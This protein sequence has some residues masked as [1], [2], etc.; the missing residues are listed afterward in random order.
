MCRGLTNERQN[1]PPAFDRPKVRSVVSW[2]W[3]YMQACLRKEEAPVKI[4]VSITIELSTTTV[5]S[6]LLIL[7]KAIFSALK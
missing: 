5:F 6:K 2:I 4:C 7:A 3:E 1:A